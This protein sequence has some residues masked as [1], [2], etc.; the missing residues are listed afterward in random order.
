MTAVLNSPAERVRFLKFMVV[1]AMGAVIDFGVMN[2]LTHFTSASLVVAGTISYA[3]SGGPITH[4]G[5][6]SVG[7]LGYYFPLVVGTVDAQ[8]LLISHIGRVDME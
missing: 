2:L 7:R 3:D 5:G 4:R 8:K 1:G 6:E